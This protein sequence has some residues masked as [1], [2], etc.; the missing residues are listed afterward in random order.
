[1]DSWSGGYRNA[2]GLAITS[3]SAI[4][5]KAPAHFKRVFGRVAQLAGDDDA[6]CIHCGVRRRTIRHLIAADTDVAQ[7]LEWSSYLD[8]RRA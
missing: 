1:M 8:A 4:S 2:S 6:T 3:R 5:F 7:Q